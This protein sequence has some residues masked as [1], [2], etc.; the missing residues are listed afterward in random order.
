MKKN[1]FSKVVKTAGLLAIAMV[2]STEPTMAN[3]IFGQQRTL[4]ATQHAYGN[5][6]QEV[7]EVKTYVF[8]ILVSTRLE[9][10]IIEEQAPP[11]G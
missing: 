9:F 10:V 4:I 3:P 5:V 8:G 2:L 1:L 11:E 6:G 7:W